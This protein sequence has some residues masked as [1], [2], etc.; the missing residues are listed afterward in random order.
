MIVIIYWYFIIEGD[1]AGGNATLTFTLPDNAASLSSPYIYERDDGPATPNA[2]DVIYS[3]SPSCI[4]LCVDADGNDATWKAS[5]PNPP[6]SNTLAQGFF[7]AFSNLSFP[8]DGSLCMSPI[9][10]N[11]D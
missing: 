11:C 9:F 1:T 3:F 6:S 2:Y 4:A 10:N 5:F 7:P 8:D